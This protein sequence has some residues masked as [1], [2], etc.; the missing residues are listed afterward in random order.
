MISVLDAAIRMKMPYGK[1]RDWLLCRGLIAMVGGKTM[2]PDPTAFEAAAVKEQLMLAPVAQVIVAPKEVPKA[3]VDAVWVSKRQLLANGPFFGGMVAEDRLVDQLTVHGKWRICYANR[4]CRYIINDW[5]EPDSWATPL[6]ANIN[7]LMDVLSVGAKKV[8]GKDAEA[9]N[10]LVMIAMEWHTCL[11]EWR[12]GLQRGLGRYP[13]SDFAAR[14]EKAD[15]TFYRQEWKQK[16]LLPL[17]PKNFEIIYA[18][19]K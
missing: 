18:E 11:Q 6:E 14:M 13:S 15:K 19:E 12:L 17:Y 10:K 5:L 8:K 1:A 4:S 16:M 7:K 3:P 9:V 2:V